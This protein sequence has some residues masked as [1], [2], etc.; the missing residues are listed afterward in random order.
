MLGAK[1]PEK[2]IKIG[3][4]AIFFVFGIFSMYEG[5]SR[6]ALFIWAIALAIVALTGYIFLRKPGIKGVV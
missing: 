5:G 3:A 4:S 1:L 2:A 6:F